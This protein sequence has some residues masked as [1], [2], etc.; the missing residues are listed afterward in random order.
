LFSGSA[1]GM[2]ALAFAGTAAAL[3]GAFAVG[4]GV[5][6]EVDLIAY[7][8]SRHFP[9]A[10][11]GAFYGGVYGAFLIGGAAGP[12]LIGFLFDVSGSYSVPLVVS[13]ALLGGAALLALRIPGEGDLL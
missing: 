9:P 5:G 10:S 11:Y 12:A 2:L 8:V 6:A 1:A 3:P 4:L 13:A 7:L